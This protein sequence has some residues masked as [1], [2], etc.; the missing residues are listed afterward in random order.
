M[1]PNEA[2]NRARL[3]LA[4]RG[5][6]VGTEPPSKAL[7]ERIRCKVRTYRPLPRALDRWLEEAL[8]Y[9]EEAQ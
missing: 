2:L 7:L 4:E 8:T 6:L 5:V 3:F 9:F 1:H